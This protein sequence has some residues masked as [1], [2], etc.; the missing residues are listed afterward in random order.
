MLGWQDS[1]KARLKRRV[2]RELR[3]K[4]ATSWRLHNSPPDCCRNKEWGAR[5]SHLTG[6]Q[7][8]DHG[9]LSP[10]GPSVLSPAGLDPCHCPHQ[11]WT[12]F[13]ETTD[14]IL[15]FTLGWVILEKSS[16]DSTGSVYFLE[17]QVHL[18]DQA[19][20]L[21]LSRKVEISFTKLCLP[22]I[23]QGILSLGQGW[24]YPSQIFSHHHLST[25]WPGSYVIASITSLILS[26][27]SFL[28]LS[29]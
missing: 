29:Q 8:Q 6:F 21:K 25:F 23:N 11:G 22:G 15:K 26:L 17:G 18:R 13:P 5:A 27:Y 7:L 16:L 20:D 28:T 10:P 12:S 4:A 9:N 24:R 3:P 2:P 19:A 14:P 1:Q